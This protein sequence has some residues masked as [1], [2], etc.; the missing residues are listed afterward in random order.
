MTLPR[1][2][3]LLSIQWFHRIEE[4]P[5]IPHAIKLLLHIEK[6][7]ISKKAINMHSGGSMEQYF[8]VWEPHHDPSS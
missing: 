6:C 4:C 5:S 2:A 8:Y 3:Q 1:F 7:V